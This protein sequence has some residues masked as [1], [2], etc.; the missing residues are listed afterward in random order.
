M[1]IQTKI[2]DLK[3][4]Y[5]ID[6]L[7][8]S[9]IDRFIGLFLIEQ[10]ISDL[11]LGIILSSSY[12]I[13]CFFNPI[14]SMHADYFKHQYRYAQIS[15]FLSGIIAPFIVIPYFWFNINKQNILFIYLLIINMV[16]NIPYK[17]Y[18]PIMES[19]TMVRLNN[20]KNLYGKARSFGSI[21]WGLMHVVIGVLLDL[22]LPLHSLTFLFTCMTIPLLIMLKLA[23]G[24]KHK[25]FDPYKDQLNTEYMSEIGNILL[26]MYIVIQIY[27][28]V[29]IE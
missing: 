2:W 19:L 17:L 28:S 25:S 7:R 24:N 3:A 9:C 21:A 22:F 11:E 1:K 6:I 5:F 4:L 16:F 12:I 14:F 18:I 8:S 27:I 26:Y 20:E 23:F 10:G 15:I 13:S 29:A